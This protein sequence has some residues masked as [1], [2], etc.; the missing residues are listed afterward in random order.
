M[1]AC[2]GNDQALTLICSGGTW[3]SNGTCGVNQLCDTAAGVNQGKCT[4]VDPL[5]VNESPGQQICSADAKSIV[6]CGADLVSHSTIT[7]CTNQTCLNAQDGG[8]PAC[9]GMCSPGQQN[10]VACGIC[11]T[12]TQTCNASGTWQ[13]GACVG[14]GVCTAG[15][16]QSC[17]TYGTQA[18]GT[19]C[20]WDVCSCPPA[21]V[22]TPGMKQ[23]AA[24]ASAVQTC[25]ACGQWG[26]GVACSG[27]TLNCSNDACVAPP[28]CA[29][30]GPGMTSCP[31]GTGS[32]SCCTSLDVSAGTYYRTYA[33]NGSGPTGEA[34]PATLSAFR[35]DKYLVT[36]GRFRQFVT[37]W[38]NG[39]LPAAGSGKHTHLNAGQ[40]LANTA[41]SGTYET[42]WDAAT[43]N[44][45]TDVDPTTANLTNCLGSN[46]FSTWTSSPGSQEDLPINC[47][48]WYEAYAFCIWDGGFL[49]SEAEW[50]Y[51][52]AGGSQQREFPWG[53]AVPGTANRYSIYS[54]YYSSGSMSCST[55]V[56]NIA[57]VGTA[58]L[59]VG[60]WGQLDLAGEMIERTSDWWDPSGGYP[61]PCTD[62]AYLGAPSNRMSRGGSFNESAT[63]ML[64]TT[65][66]AEGPDYRG[67]D[68]GFRCARLP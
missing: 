18:C 58:S 38:N 61:A 62:C 24:V 60:L 45:A 52:A 43:W 22:C 10:P 6:Q 51:A 15:I 1:L 68:T 25:D 32:E 4:P 35:L 34:D 9:A 49:P 55:G 48:N 13:S 12:D 41:T 64:P 21:P 50:E 36:V 57:P 20:E 31:A 39:Y 67:F 56:T 26:A 8:A 19:N 42:G 63:A 2:N 65:R 7:V 5:C 30:G 66:V 59:G 29:P 3:A 44:N 23:C 28:S 16:V 17:N 33:N 54:C 27:S 40:G 47:A 11:G 46:L 14:Q 53:N 37:A